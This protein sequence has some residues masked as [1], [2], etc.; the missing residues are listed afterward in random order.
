[1]TDV[2]DYRDNREGWNTRRLTGL[3]SVPPISAFAATLLD[4]SDAEEARDTLGAQIAENGFAD[5]DDST[6]SFTDG[7]RT[8]EIAPAVTSFVYYQSTQKY[9]VSSADS[10]VIAD[11]EGLHFIYYD[12][13]TLSETTTFS[14]ALITTYALVG[15]V[16][17]DATNNEG[18]YV[19]DERHGNTMDSTTHAYNHQTFGARHQSGLGLGN[20]T[21]GGDGDLDIHAQLSVSDGGIWDEDIQVSIVDGSPQNLSTIAEIP[22]FYRSG[23]SGEWRKIAAT[24]FPITTTGTGRAA[25]NEDTGA[26]W[27]LTEVTSNDFV[28]VHLYASPDILNPIIGIVGQA[29]YSTANNAEAGADIELLSLQNEQIGSLTPE[30]VPIATVIFQ[31]GNGKSNTVKSSVEPTADGSD[32]VDWRFVQGGVGAAAST[33]AVWGDVQGTLANQTDLQ[34]A[35]DAKL[36]AVVASDVDSEA[37]TDGWVLT[38]DGASGAA[39]EVLPAGGGEV[40]DLSASVTWANIPDANVPQSAVTQHEAALAVLESQISDLQAYLVDKA[41]VEGVL[42]GEIS[43]HTHAG[44]GGGISVLFAQGTATGSMDDTEIN[45]TWDDTPD[46]DD[47][48]GVSIGGGDDSEITLTDAGVYVFDVTLN[49]TNANRTELAIRTYI[50]PDGVSGFTQDTDLLIHNYVSRDSD[51]NIGGLSLH[52]ALDVGAGAKV[53]FRG[54]GDT[55]GTCVARTDGTWLRITK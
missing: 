21:V 4:D 17:W 27:Q 24:S 11:T 9:T 25:W 13:S 53:Q 32:Y 20:M 46:V 29:E 37:S 28:L 22:M 1:M 2:P 41:D 42:T 26:T 15:V 38:S 6:I 44:G 31:T 10:V 18:V 7:S 14:L 43:S 35:L 39:W 45:L 50:D 47:I 51:Q 48:S 52:I 19:G 49:S 55:D 34:T 36:S 40:N 23:A 54:F 3:I 33:S 30:F 12:G 16:Y 5:R 8:F